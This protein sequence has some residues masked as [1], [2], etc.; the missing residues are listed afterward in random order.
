MKNIA[1]I[2]ILLLLV[3]ACSSNQ[4]RGL[5]LISGNM[6]KMAGEWLYAEELEV[7]QVSLLDSVQI[8][9]EGSFEISLEVTE[10][11]FYML[12]TQ[13]ENYVLF[14]MEPGSN[15]I[16]NTS[17]AFFVDGYEVQGSEDSQLLKEFELFMISQKRK[18]D[19][20]AYEF[21]NSKGSEN[22]YEKKIQLDSAYLDIYNQQ[23]V[24][25]F[26]F[27]ESN[28]NSLVSLIVINRKLGNNIILDEEEDFLYFHR[29]DSALMSKYPTNKHTADNHKRIKQIRMD[30]FD[31]FVADQKLEPGKKAPNIVLKD[32]SGQFISLKDLAGKKVL[33]YFWAGWNAKS[34]QDN[35]KLISLYP[36]LKNNEIEILGVSL[37]EHIKVWKGAISLDKTPWIQGSDL[38]GI[39]SKVVKNYNLIDELPFYYLVDEER[40]I[41]FRNR[42]LAEVISKLDE[43]F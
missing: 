28:P 15:I 13:K 22:F 33:I 7:S 30:K 14:V 26:N 2:L 11:G 3:N 21:N 43:L 29:L 16:I 31:R 18:V 36:K 25:V 17:N 10:Q 32:T 4:K 12:R 37:D 42:D 9:P 40:K 23:R 24:Y 27:V 6:P 8:D 1:Q 41:I 39:D 20:L 38:M 19:S 5:A 35:R 34:R